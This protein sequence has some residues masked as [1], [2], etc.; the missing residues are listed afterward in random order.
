MSISTHQYTEVLIVNVIIENSV[1]YSCVIYM[2]MGTWS[3]FMILSQSNQLTL[4]L[5]LEE[6]NLITSATSF[7]IP[8]TSNSGIIRIPL[9]LANSM[10]SRTSSGVYVREG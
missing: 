3:G 9:T 7:T 4:I 6:S 8:G 2:Y 10:I 1:A 5:L